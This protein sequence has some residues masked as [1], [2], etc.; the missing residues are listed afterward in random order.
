MTEPNLPRIPSAPSSVDIAITGRCN[1]NCKYCY[2]ADEMAASHD[3][4]TERWLTFFEEL[5]NL[6]VQR[7]YI[8]GGEP[9]TR[10]DLF[11]LVD[12]IIANRMRYAL[13]TNGTLVTEEV[14]SQFEDGKRRQRLDYIQISVDGSR[15]EVHN[16][17][18]PDSFALVVDGLRR[19]VENGLP[20]FAR[21]T[22]N[23]HNVDDLE[24]ITH[25]LL[26]DIGVCSFSTNETFPCG[27]IE[28]QA[29]EIILTPAQRQ[30]AMETLTKLAALHNGRIQANAGPLAL[31]RKFKK[32]EEAL[33][34][35]ETSFPGRG[36]LCACG[37]VFTKVAVNPDGTIVPCHLLDAP[38]MGSVGVDDL[39]QIW[40]EHP[41]LDKLRRRHTIPLQTLDTCR[42]CP[43][44]GFCTGG[45]PAVGFFLTGEL[46][47]RNPMECYRVHKGEDPYFSLE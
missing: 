45:C 16:R 12:G 8:T 33:T 26:E 20:V 23:R 44:Q 27:I 2:Y 7:I 43:Y 5:G 22:V 21:V 6:A 41:L 36:T 15:A 40:L 42:D 1:L 31:A 18:R 19:L 10:P 37:S 14:L 35:G 38:S 30:Q 11:E 13:L 24:N 9:L 3:L 47:G 32:I 34:A 4:P 39:Q 29:E 25:L 17:S 28:R 46:N